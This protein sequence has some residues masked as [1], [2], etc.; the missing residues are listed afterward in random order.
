MILLTILARRFPFF[1]SADDVEALIEIASIFGMK[2][3]KQCAILHGAVFECTLPTIGE[4][5]HPLEE[6]IQWSVSNVRPEDADDLDPETKE[7]VKFLKLLLEM[8][9]RKRISARGALLSSF[10]KE[11]PDLETEDDEMDVLVGA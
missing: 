10:L 4:A 9:P 8:D 6:L 1:N 11:K 3:M 7:I 2:R 5:G